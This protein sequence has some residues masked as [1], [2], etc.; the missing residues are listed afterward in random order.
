[1]TK[2]FKEKRQDWDFSAENRNYKAGPNG[3]S[4]TKKLKLP[5]LWI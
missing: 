1:M 5:K 3:Y 4:K 2:I